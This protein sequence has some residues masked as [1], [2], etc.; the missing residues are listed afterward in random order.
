MQVELLLID[1]QQWLWPSQEPTYS[2]LLDQKNPNL[3]VVELTSSW[4]TCQREITQLA[5][6]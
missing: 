1:E 4:K 6:V 2:S 5:H 3:L